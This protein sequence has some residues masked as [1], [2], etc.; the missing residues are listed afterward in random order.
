M[1]EVKLTQIEK[2]IFV[3]RAQKVMIDSDLAELYGVLTK[4]S[5]KPFNGI[6][7]DFLKTSCFS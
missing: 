7:I 4:T 2:I 6:L 1:N 3:I 5:I